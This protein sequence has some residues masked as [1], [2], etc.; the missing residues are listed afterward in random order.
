AREL[1][2]PVRRVRLGGLE[3]ADARELVSAIAGG[4]R[5]IDRDVLANEAEGHPLFIDALVRHR[6]VHGAA[7]R[8]RR[9]GGPRAQID[10]L[11]APP[12]VLSE[13]G[14]TAGAPL[15]QEIAAQVAELEFERFDE[16]AQTLRTAHLVR[17]S[18]ARRSDSIEVYHDRVREAVATLLGAAA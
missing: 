17:T 11:P 18:G 5:T 10:A 2:V 6:L 15:K 14:A 9:D 7:G 12:R 13:V 3:G 4:D 1:S 8:P 16:L